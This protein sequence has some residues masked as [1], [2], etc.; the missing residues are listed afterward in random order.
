MP[1]VASV[2]WVLLA[3]VAPALLVGGVRA[4][5]LPRVKPESV[6]LSA[7]KLTRIDELFETAHRIA[8]IHDGRLSAPRRTADWTRA[9]IGLEMLGTGQGQGVSHAA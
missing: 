4:D 9:G 2:R 3:L 6:G 7:E 8:V 1:R 5:D